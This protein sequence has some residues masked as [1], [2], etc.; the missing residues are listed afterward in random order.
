MAEESILYKKEEKAQT[1]MID[2][3]IICLG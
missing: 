3:R 1:L 2:E